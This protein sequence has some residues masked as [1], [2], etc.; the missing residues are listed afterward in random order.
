M[1]NKTTGR[2]TAR[3]DMLI[4]FSRMATLEDYALQEVHPELFNS[5]FSRLG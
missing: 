4:L 3:A 1:E 5:C 2:Q